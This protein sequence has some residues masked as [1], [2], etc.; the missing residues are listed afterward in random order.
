MHSVLSSQFRVFTQREACRCSPIY[1]SRDEAHRFCPGG[2]A[3]LK[4]KH[5]NLFLKQ[6][7]S[8]AINVEKFMPK[9][10]LEK[11]VVL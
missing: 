1:S 3:A 10:A 7:T 5:T 11:K 8:F 2:E 9:G 4:K 6:L